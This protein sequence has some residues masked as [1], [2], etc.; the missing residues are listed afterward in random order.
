MLLKFPKVVTDGLETTGMITPQCLNLFLG[1]TNC[2]LHAVGFFNFG[3][4]LLHHMTATDYMYS[5]SY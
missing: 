3:K 2:Y 4:V 1:K 5:I